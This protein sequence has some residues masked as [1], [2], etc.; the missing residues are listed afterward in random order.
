ML[1]FCILICGCGDTFRPVATPL[2]QPTPTP[3]NFRL[4]VFTACQLMQNPADPGN[5]TDKICNPAATNGSV[6]VDVNVSGD[7][8]EGVVPVGLGPV[9]ALVENTV[10]VTVTTADFNNDTITQHNDSHISSTP[11]VS[12]PVTIGLP[13]GARPI[14]MV[15]SNGTIYVAES[16]RNVVGVLGN[17]PLSLSAEVPVGTTPVNMAVLPNAKKI[18][19]VNQGSGNV[20]VISPVDNSVITT[21]PVGSS[22][23]FAVPSA[24]SS[25]VFVLNRGSGTVTVIDATTDAIIST[26]QVGSSPNFAAFD[27][28]NQRVVVTNSGSSTVSIISA[29]PSSPQFLTVLRNVTVGTNP[30]AVTVLADGTRSYVANAGSNSVSVV[31]NLSLT[32]TKTIPV[33]TFPISIASDAESAKVLTANR[34]S[35]NVS[36]INTSTDSEVADPSGNPVRIAAPSGLS[37]I[38]VAVGPG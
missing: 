7:S 6:A 20:T 2:P 32:V 4:A 36:V 18:Y 1:G 5:A 35:S 25:R 31:N 14:S 28:Q 15:T 17:S 27:A 21:V 3:Q 16:G 11:F 13:S 19:V 37:P 8:V 34:D 23:A 30:V 38:F 9:F 26:I 24:D 10:A 22:P 29:D 12:N 33:G